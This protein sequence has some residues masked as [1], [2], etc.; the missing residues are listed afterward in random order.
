MSAK[1]HEIGEELTKEGLAKLKVGQVLVFDYEGSRTE[2]KITK[3]NRKSHKCW[4]KE[5]KLY[6]QQEV[7]D[8]APG[9]FNELRKNGGDDE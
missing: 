2:L 1:V 9:E 5:V 3:I 4:V 6:S 8:M 7:D